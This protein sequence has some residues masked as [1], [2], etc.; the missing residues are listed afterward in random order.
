MFALAVDELGVE[1]PDAGAASSHAG[2]R[3]A[4]G[5]GAA[6]PHGVRDFKE[7]A[8]HFKGQAPPREAQRFLHVSGAS[9][10]PRIF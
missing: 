1:S 2:E 6:I 8:F 5:V 7:A 9:F 4:A 10:R 3:E